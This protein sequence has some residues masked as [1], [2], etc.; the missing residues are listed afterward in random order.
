MKKPEYSPKQ[1]R[2]FLVALLLVAGLVTLRFTRGNPSL[3]AILWP[4]EAILVAFFLALPKL[5]YPIFKGITIGSGYFG[6][7]MFLVISTITF[8]LVLT[9]IALVMRLFGKRFMQAKIDPRLSTYYE[10]GSGVHDIE[11]QY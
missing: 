5:F 8:Y 4:I 7:F 11:K 10:E 6:S 3:R 1:V 2:I 9:P